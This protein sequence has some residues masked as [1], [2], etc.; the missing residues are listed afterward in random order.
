MSM[1]TE[2]KTEL[3]MA[4]F[5]L[6]TWGVWIRQLPGAGVA[7]SGIAVYTRERLDHAHDSTPDDALAELVDRILGQMKVKHRQLWDVAVFKYWH[8]QNDKT[9]AS[10]MQMSEVTYRTN[11]RLLEMYVDSA[12]THGVHLQ[13][14]VDP[15]T[16]NR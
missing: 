9:A 11:R 6:E 13:E 15:L 12:L 1:T 16:G 14:G 8:Q 2:A 5:A 10:L 7:M 3:A 4:S